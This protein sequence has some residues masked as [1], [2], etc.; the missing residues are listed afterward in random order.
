MKY[1]RNDPRLPSTHLTDKEIIRL[2]LKLGDVF[3]ISTER[4]CDVRPSYLEGW[5]N[6]K[7]RPVV[8]S[9]GYIYGQVVY[10]VLLPDW[11]QGRRRRRKSPRAKSRIG[12]I[13]T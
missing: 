11:N 12:R 10:E 9:R 2:C 3:E 7:E 13:G 4:Y 8:S 5:L 6:M 1:E